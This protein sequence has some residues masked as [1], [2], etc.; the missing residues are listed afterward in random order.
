MGTLR[1]QRYGR[2]PPL[3]ISLQY[4]P[5]ARRGL[6]FAR[7]TPSFARKTRSGNHVA[8]AASALGD[9]TIVSAKPT[10]QREISPAALGDDVLVSGTV[11]EATFML[12]VPWR[13]HGAGCTVSA[14][15]AVELQA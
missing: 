6:G 9:A 2:S 13:A 12:L 7:K 10:V 15:S 4:M 8:A 3:P 11:G 1:P 5:L 14:T